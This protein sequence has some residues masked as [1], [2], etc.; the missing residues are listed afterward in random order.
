MP[1]KVQV[2]R[3]KNPAAVYFGYLKNAEL[4]ILTFGVKSS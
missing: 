1:I 4:N 3:Q 2:F